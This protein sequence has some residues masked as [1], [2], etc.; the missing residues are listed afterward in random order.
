MLFPLQNGKIHHFIYKFPR[1]KY[2]I[3]HLN[4]KIQG[5]GYGEHKLTS[6]SAPKSLSA[7]DSTAAGEA[8][9]EVAQLSDED[10]LGN[11]A[12]AVTL[13]PGC[14]GRLVIEMERYANRPS[15]AFP[16]DR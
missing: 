11:C 4:A 16:W 6:V 7:V 8:A 15:L 1:F 5:G 2:T 9:G 13:E 10:G 3:H 12:F 14:A